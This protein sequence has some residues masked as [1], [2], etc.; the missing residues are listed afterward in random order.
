MPFGLGLAF[1]ICLSIIAIS[2][3]SATVSLRNAAIAVQRQNPVPVTGSSGGVVPPSNPPRSIPPSPNFLNVCSGYNYDD[4]S[5]CV[6]TT[7]QAIDNARSAEGVSAMTLPSDWSSLTPQQQLFVATN[8]ERT[9]RA[10]PAMSGMAQ[11]LDQASQQAAANNEDPSP[12]SGFRWTMWGGNWAAAVGNP[13]EAIYLWMYD[14]GPGSSNIDCTSTNSSGC[15][16]HRDNVLMQMSC[17]SCVMGTGL[18]SN[19]WRGEPSWTE[20]LVLTS[21]SPV[22]DFSW[23]PAPSGPS[24]VGPAVG[25]A[26]TADGNGYWIADSTGGVFTF[27]DAPFYGAAAG[28]HLNAPIVGIAPTPDGHGYWLVASDGGIFTYG[29]APFY[30]STGALRLNAPI[31]GIAST[32]DGHGYWLVASDGGIFT[33]GDAPFYGSTGAMRLNRPIVGMAPTSDGGGYWLVASDGGIFTYGDAPFYGST[34]AMRLNRSIAGVA[35]TSDG[36]GYWL[37]GS[38]GG[39]FTYGDAPFVGSAG[40]LQLVAPVVSMASPSGA[41]YWLLGSDGGIFSYGVPFRGSMG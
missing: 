7:L 9:A 40:A 19:A 23:S 20:L 35:P 39:I 16:G 31:V 4:S 27:G 33:Y 41:G 3:S 15:W 25:I 2:A 30:G 38:D 28:S 24:L 8:L 37:V 12:P 32:P 13:L 6:S 34:G 22:L 5:Q 10:L 36:H 11:A 17:G 29:D 18:V 14:D 21:G 26:P 1:C